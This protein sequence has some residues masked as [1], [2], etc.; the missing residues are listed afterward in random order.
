MSNYNSFSEISEYV[1]DTSPDPVDEYI[2]SF[3]EF[4]EGWNFG[5]GK[6]PSGEVIEKAIQLYRI[7]KSFGLIGD[8]FPVGDGEIEISFSYQDHFIDILITAQ[9][10]LEYTYEIGIGDEYNEIEHVENIHFEEAKS[11]LRTLEEMKLCDSLEY[12][13]Q[14]GTFIGIR[15]DSKAVVLEGSVLGSPSLTE[16]VFPGIMAPQ[17][18][19]T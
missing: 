10:T 4:P 11:K 19:A 12:S 1:K 8:A 14:N 2:R 9:N 5:E 6:A 3:S 17:Y 7:G 18:A 13:M 16:I 15:E